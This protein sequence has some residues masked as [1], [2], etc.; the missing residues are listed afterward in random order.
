MCN[1]G[2]REL[3]GVVFRERDE[4]CRPRELTPKRRNGFRVI[5]HYSSFQGFYKSCSV[6]FSLLR[7]FPPCFSSVFLGFFSRFL[8]LLP[9]CMVA[10]YRRTCPA[11]V[12]GWSAA[13][14]WRAC[15][16]GWSVGVQAAGQRR[17][18]KRQQ[19]GCSFGKAKLHFG[20]SIYDCFN[21]ILNWI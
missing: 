21:C 3:G 7:S 17:R 8:S 2:E 14:G 12:A 10:F 6:L 9:S 18:Y 11:T 19:R 16:G 20:P 5:F 15:N 4:V 13:W 1:G